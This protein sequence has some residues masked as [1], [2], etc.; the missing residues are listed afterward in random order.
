[1]IGDAVGVSVEDRQTCNQGDLEKCHV[2]NMDRLLM[3][4]GGSVPEQ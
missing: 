3:S 2:G 1:M 4:P